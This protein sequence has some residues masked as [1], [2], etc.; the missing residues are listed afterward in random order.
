MASPPSL[1]DYTIV[2]R[3]G[4]GGFGTAYLVQSK[5][6]SKQYCLKQIRID[7]TDKFLHV[8]PISLSINH[9]RYVKAKSIEE[10]NILHKLHS[11]YIIHY[12]A[13]FFTNTSNLNIV[14]E[15][16]PNGSL[17][18]IISV[19]TPLHFHSSY[20]IKIRLF[21]ERK[22]FYPNQRY[23]GTSF[24]YPP[25]FSVSRFPISFQYLSFQIF[26]HRRFYIVTL[27][28]KMS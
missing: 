17:N 15:Y 3:L 25:A 22:D 8:P 7:L 19:F 9:L 13:S 14:M 18:N 24:K 21:K 26:T 4:E 20:Q 12:K 2:K 5:L 23:G 16:A 6:D 27:N 11:P 10:A 1:S 28:L